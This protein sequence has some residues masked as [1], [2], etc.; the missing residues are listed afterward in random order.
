MLTPSSE[1]K[2]GFATQV[3]ITNDGRTITGI[4]KQET[5]ESLTLNQPNEKSVTISRDKIDERFSQKVS[6][7]PAFDRLLTPQ[8]TAD[9]VK[10]LLER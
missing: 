10:Y 7:M 9:L 1:I 8:Q 3:I 6:A 4:L 5:G 2:E